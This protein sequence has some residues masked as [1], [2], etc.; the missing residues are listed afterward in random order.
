MERN[1]KICLFIIPVIL[2]F[3]GSRLGNSYINVSIFKNTYF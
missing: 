1:V 3:L 2:F